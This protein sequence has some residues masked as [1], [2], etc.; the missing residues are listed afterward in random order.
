[1]IYIIKFFYS[2]LLPPGIFIILM[3]I[4]SIWLYRSAKRQAIILSIFTSVFYTFSTP[5]VS[6]LLMKSLESRYT[7]SANIKGDVLIMLG[8]GAISDAPDIDGA[9]QLSGAAANRLLTTARLYHKTKLPII[10]SGGEV[11]TDSG[12]EALIAKRQLLALGVPE[13]KIIIESKSRNTEENAK[14]TKLLLEKYN[15]KQPI[16][17]T[18][19]F[20]MERSVRNF[21]TIGI[22]TQP[23]PTD[24]RSS[25]HSSAYANKFV[26]SAGSLSN[27]SIILKE[28]LGI[29]A[30]SF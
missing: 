11:F 1:V 17:I 27:V 21:N 9:G 28:Y 13:D 16:L 4:L 3:F 5:Y 6:D 15:F 14:Y 23:Y 19:A 25:P 7:P 18:S 26:P 29:A 24:Y 30:L 8:G 22:H 2:F 10:L 12:N 20:H